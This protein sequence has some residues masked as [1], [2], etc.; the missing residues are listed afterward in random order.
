MLDL[1][2]IPAT[3]SYTVPEFYC[4]MYHCKILSVM[5]KFWQMN[6]VSIVHC[7]LIGFLN[8]NI[9]LKKLGSQ[10]KFNLLLNYPFIYHILFHDKNIPGVWVKCTNFVKFLQMGQNSVTNW[11]IP[12]SLDYWWNFPRI[13]LK[14][15]LAPLWDIVWCYPILTNQSLVKKVHFSIS[16]IKLS[17]TSTS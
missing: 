9:I 3:V 11:S 5:L 14:F 7:Y 10:R 6:L 4:D 12:L 8:N 2:T 1:A 13:S 15:H 17:T 16:H